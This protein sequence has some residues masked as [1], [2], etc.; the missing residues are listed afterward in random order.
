MA[1]SGMCT[2]G[3]IRH[4]LQNN[5]SREECSIVFVGF[6]ASATLARRIIDGEKEV[7]IYGEKFTVQAK[8]YTING[9]SAHADQVELLAWHKKIGNPKRTF[10]VHGEQE[11][12]RQFSKKLEGTTVEMPV[13]NESFTL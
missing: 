6:A 2:V 3:R 7:K 1:G 13:L 10:L 5:I 8:I 12:M 11:T 4:H 9:F